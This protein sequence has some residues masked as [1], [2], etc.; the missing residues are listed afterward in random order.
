[1]GVILRD[2]STVHIPD[3][4]EHPD[5]KNARVVRMTNA[6]TVLGVPMMREDRVIGGMVLARYVVR[7]FSEREIE[8]VQTFV[9]QAA[10]AI[11]NVRLFDETK[12]RLLQQTATAEVLKAISRAAFD[13]QSV[14]DTLVERAA[15]LCEADS[16][17]INTPQGD[18]FK[19][20]ASTRSYPTELREWD[21]EHPMALD[22]KSV[23][24]RVLLER[25]TVQIDNIVADPQYGHA[26]PGTP[27]RSILG[28]PLLRQ[29]EPIG[30]FVL[31]RNAIRPFTKGN[32]DLVETF[33][34]QAV[35][36]IENARLITEI[37]EK[38]AQL[39]I[40]SRHKSEFLATMSHELRTP[41]NAIIGF[42]EVLLQQ[43]FG[44]LNEKQTEYLNDVLSSGRHLLSLINDILDLSKIEA[45]RMELDIDRFSLV[46]TVQNAITMVRERAGNHGIALNVDVAPDLDLI[47]ADPRKVK[48]V[49]FNL[50]SN[51]VKFTPDGGRVEIAA[52]R[53]N[54]DVIV[55]VTDTGIGIAPEDQERIFEEFQQARRQSERSREGT[56]LGLAL[57]KRFIELHGGRIWVVSELGKGSTF[58]FTLPIAAQ[59]RQMVRA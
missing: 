24:G 43:M 15:Q 30:V 17:S 55:T 37:Q 35:I 1:M 59:A 19:T 44:A 2:R 51:A 29:G 38:S 16:C 56:G 20:V 39:E 36:A 46:E 6:R 21:L 41:L 9:D 33:A 57:A 27:T 8:L 11:E 45:G 4:T 34:D 5:F 3:A 22:R 13:L 49:L 26:A 32:I 53:G 23:T 31:R 7:P 52:R 42:S 28:V 18:M 40:A 58:T 25:R 48:Q 14:L 47:E 10:I 12:E 54:G 50:L